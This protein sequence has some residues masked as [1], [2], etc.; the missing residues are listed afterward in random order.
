MSV[1]GASPTSAT[2]HQQHSGAEARLRGRWLLMARIACLGI[3][4]FALII[5]VWGIPIRY[6]QLGT[7]CTT[8]VCGDQQPTP[9]SISAFQAAGISPGFYAAYTGTVEVLFALVFLILAALIFWRKS[10]TSIG[11]LTALFLVTYGVM[12]TD[13]TALAA[14][15]RAWAIPV[16]IL[17]PLAYIC[18][19]LFLYLFPDGHFVPRWTRFVIAAW[20]PLFL[21]SATF[22][23]PEVFVA[24]L[25]GFLLLSLAAQIY[26]YRRVSTSTQRQQTKWVVFG[27]CISLFI[28]ISIIS[29]VNMLSLPQSPGDWAFFVGN[30]SIYLFGAIIPLSIAIAILRSRLWDIDALINKAL[31]YGLLT[32]LLAALYAGLIIGLESLAGAIGGTS[33]QQ[34]VVLVISTLAIA[35]LF[36]PLRRRLQALIDRRF[37]RRKYDAA[38]T[39]AAFSATLRG[40]VDLSQLRAHLLA[41]VEETMQPTLVTLW[42]LPQE[43]RGEEQ[44]SSASSDT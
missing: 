32:A 43:R 10:N 39:L 19:S 41:I 11:L 36:Q 38:R 42:L 3:S 5:W 28:S 20:I 35:A 30:T 34:P 18:L 29:T 23:P 9:A 13:A 4:L 21:L 8:T 17:Q 44:Q 22:L 15:V 6:A 37:Y 27:V 2:T 24:L 33:A 7:V 31:V 12:Q 14:A 25:F 1:P 26:R 16:N 40:E